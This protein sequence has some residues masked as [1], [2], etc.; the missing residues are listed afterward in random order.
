MAA[1]R[2]FPRPAEGGRLR[3]GET[4]VAFSRMAAQLGER[5]VEAEINPVFVLPRARVFVPPMASWYWARPATQQ[6]PLRNE[7]RKARHFAG[8]Q[9]S[10]WRIRM[11]TLVH[12]ASETTGAGTRKFLTVSIG[13]AIMLAIIMAPSPADLSPAGQRVIAVMVFVVLM[14]ITEAIPY[15]V[16]AIALVFLLILALGFSPAGSDAGAILGTAKAIPLALSGFSN[17]GWL[18]VAAGLAMAA[19]ITGT[20]LEKRV[21]YLILKLVGPVPTRSC[22]ASS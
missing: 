8:D 5:L 12:A 14:W 19:A 15:G 11:S 3:A 13:L 21:A 7:H 10:K 17:S 22:S 20:G 2:W 9:K 16:S 6:V 4:I 1:A 18:F